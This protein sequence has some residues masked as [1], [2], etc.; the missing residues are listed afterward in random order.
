MKKLI[1]LCCLLVN[2]VCFQHV[3]IF[4]AEGIPHKKELFRTHLIKNYN[5]LLRADEDRWRQEFCR[6]AIWL[7]KRGYLKA[8]QKAYKLANSFEI[9]D[10]ILQ[11]Y[12]Q[13][14]DDLSNNG[15]LHLTVGLLTFLFSNHR[16]KPLESYSFQEGSILGHLYLFLAIMTFGEKKNA[17]GI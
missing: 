14:I 4:A 12:K 16:L 1:L 8:S 6:L 5:I 2:M 7:K 10:E 3:S 15:L 11:N 17:S 9:K 13:G